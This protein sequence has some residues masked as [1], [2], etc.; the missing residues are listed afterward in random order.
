[1][2]KPSYIGFDHKTYKWSSQIDYEREPSLYEIG[3]GQQ[4]VLVCEPYK[5]QIGKHWRF[6]NPKIAEKSAETIYKM[7]ISYLLEGDFVGADMAKKYLH[8]G[9]TRAR[10]YWNHSSG[11]KWTRE[12][13]KWEI[14]PKDHNV[15]RFF[16]SSNIFQD[17]WKR[18]RENEQYREMKK[19]FMCR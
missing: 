9:F 18:A 14:L 13:G 12:N 15:E 10:R 8:M 16:R 4:G 11:K 17:Y 2:N 3:R 19:E 1:M 6:K 7:F 5:S